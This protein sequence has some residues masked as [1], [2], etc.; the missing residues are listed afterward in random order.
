MLI[1]NEVKKQ[2]SLNHPFENDLSFLYGTIFVGPALSDHADNRNVCIFA[3]GEVDRSPTG[4]GVSARMAIHHARGE[5]KNGE[6][7]VIE[8]I[9]GTTFRGCVVK[10]TIFG[11]YQAVI[12]E[13]EGSAFITGK[14]EFVLDPDDPLRHGF[15]LR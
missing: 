11:P 15:I 7:M 9:V 4:T 8:S 14:S 12:P 6:S 2:I 13:V 1:K 10:E 5:L 3:E